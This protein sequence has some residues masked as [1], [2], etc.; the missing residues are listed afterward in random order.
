[1]QSKVDASQRA[2]NAGATIKRRIASGDLQIDGGFSGKTHTE[3]T[4]K[5]MSQSKLGMFLGKENPNFGKRNACITKNGIT[6]RV[7]LEVL[8]TYLDAGW[9]RGMK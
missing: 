9:K 8:Q 3:E 5:K 4:R 6:K 2:K 1:M 7:T